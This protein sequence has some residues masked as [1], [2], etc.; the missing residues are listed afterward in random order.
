MLLSKGLVQI[1][2]NVSKVVI[3]MC[4]TNNVQAKQ[5]TFEDAE[6]KGLL[7]KNPYQMLEEMSE[8]LNIDPTSVGKRVH[9][10]GFIQKESYWGLHELTKRQEKRLTTCEM[11]FVLK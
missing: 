10:F 4:K 9:K 2:L 5:Q 1:G 6:L 3:L 11:K 7:D 8:A